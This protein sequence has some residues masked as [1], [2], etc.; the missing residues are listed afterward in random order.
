MN[1]IIY[2]IILIA[3]GFM[4]YLVYDKVLKGGDNILKDNND[5]YNKSMKELHREPIIDNEVANITLEADV[6]ICLDSSI[7]GFLLSD[8]PN[9]KGLDKIKYYTPDQNDYIIALGISTKLFNVTKLNGNT[10]SSENNKNN[11]LYLLAATLIFRYGDKTYMHDPDISCIGN[12]PFKLLPR[13][14]GDTSKVILSIADNELCEDVQFKDKKRFNIDL[15]INLK[16][17]D[18]VDKSGKSYSYNEEYNKVA[19]HYNNIIYNYIKKAAR[20]KVIR[21]ILFRR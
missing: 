15:V 3:I 2:I 11:A 21:Y 16:A 10:I 9:V 12:L 20:N 6:D 17:A 19:A 7:K 1:M 14:L 18:Y 13:K 5:Y 8:R 4:L